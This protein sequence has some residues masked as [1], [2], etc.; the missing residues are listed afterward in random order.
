MLNGSHFQ[1]ETN[2]TVAAT[3]FA[4]AMV[5]LDSFGALGV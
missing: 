1:T 4:M 5:D 2:N 3:R